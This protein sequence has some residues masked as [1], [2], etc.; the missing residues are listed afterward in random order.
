MAADSLERHEWNPPLPLR[1][2]GLEDSLKAAGGI[3][4]GYKAAEVESKEDLAKHVLEVEKEAMRLRGMLEQAEIAWERGVKLKHKNNTPYALQQVEHDQK[5]SKPSSAKGPLPEATA[6]ARAMAQAAAARSNRKAQ[7]G[8]SRRMEGGRQKAYLGSQ[9][10]MVERLAKLAEAALFAELDEM[11]GLVAALDERV[12]TLTAGC[13]G[14]GSA[15]ADGAEAASEAHTSRGAGRPGS[16]L[17]DAAA[18]GVGAGWG[19][20]AA[21]LVAAWAALGPAVLTKL[22]VR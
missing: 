13:G 17:T 7:E 5:I 4:E 6:N 2:P 20:G 3:N 22:R 15:T 8:W 1:K 21:D 19:T 12:A 11:Q 18:L 9:E 10:A 14:A 16:P